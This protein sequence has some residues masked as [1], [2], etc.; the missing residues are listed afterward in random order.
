MAPDKFEKYI[1]DKVQQREIIPS[2][3]AWNRIA[4][5]LPP[6][7]KSSRRPIVW[8]SIAASFVGILIITLYF[9]QT[10][11]QESVSPTPVVIRDDNSTERT[12]Q[13]IKPANELLETEQG[14]A[15]A[16]RPSTQQ[17]SEQMPA[18]QEEKSVLPVRD[19][20]LQ[21]MVIASNEEKEGMV[22]EAVEEKEDIFIQEKIT[23]VVAEVRLLELNNEALTEAEVDSL[24]RKAQN[25]LL[26]ERLFKSDNTV[27]AVALL[28][29][30][31][32][33]LDQSFRDQIFDRL[34]TG[35]MKV[36]TALADRNN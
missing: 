5:Q 12:Q 20:Q 35:F 2:E 1:K 11:D 21:P 26:K 7:E 32:T 3:D 23:E 10:A 9:T 24:L 33:E 22:P 27:D 34:K 8:Y 36:R 31:E 28:N 14:E 16:S 17:S 30:V 13:M 25:E 19:K 18:V 29:E 6:E 15:V 4:E